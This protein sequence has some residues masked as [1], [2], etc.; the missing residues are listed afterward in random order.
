MFSEM[1]SW[2]LRGSSSNSSSVE[3]RK[4][5]FSHQ[6][7]GGIDFNS[8]NTDRPRG[9]YFLMHPQR[10]IDEEKMSVLHQISG[11]FGKLIHSALEICLWEISMKS[12][13]ISR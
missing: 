7:K 2:N 8:V 5:A 10:W 4:K 6:Y 11:G 9:R 13:E 12:Q 3:K 1:F